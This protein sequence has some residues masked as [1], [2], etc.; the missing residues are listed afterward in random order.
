MTVSNS[1]ATFSCASGC[2]AAAITLTLIADAV[3]SE[4]A[5]NME[6]AR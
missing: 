1:C 6:P 5:P 2:V 4:P 3:V